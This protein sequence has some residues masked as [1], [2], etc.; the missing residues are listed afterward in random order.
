MLLI[1]YRLLFFLFFKLYASP[2][3]S[4]EGKFEELRR[5]KLGVCSSIH[6]AECDHAERVSMETSWIDESD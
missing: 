2:G 4:G 5:T 6:E 1:I 3:H